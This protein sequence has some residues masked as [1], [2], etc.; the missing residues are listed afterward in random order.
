MSTLTPDTLSTNEHEG[1][2]VVESL[3]MDILRRYTFML[4][5][6]EMLP[7]AKDDVASFLNWVMQCPNS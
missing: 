6:Y 5:K 7:E 3:A 1:R 2:D 4:D